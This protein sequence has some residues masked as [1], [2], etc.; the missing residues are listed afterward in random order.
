MMILTLALLGMVLGSFVSI[1][2]KRS[3]EGNALPSLVQ[4][5]VVDS[6]LINESDFF[7]NGQFHVQLIGDSLI[8]V[9]SYKSPSVGFYHISGKQR[10]RIASGDYPIGSFLPSYFD[11]PEYPIVYILDKKSES[12]LVFNVE[13][14]EFLEKIKLDLPEG[15][16]IRILGSKFKKLKTGF[17]IELASSLHDNLHPDYY[18]ESGELIYLFGENGKVKENPFLEYPNEIKVIGGSLKAIN[19]LSFTSDNQSLL[20]SFPHE[21]IIR[22]FDI[23]TFGKA[24]EEIPLPTSRY[25]DYQLTGSEGIVTFEDGLGGMAGAKKIN[26][27]TNHYFTNISETATRII[28]QTWLIGD[29]SEGLNRTSH[30]M[31]YDK[32]EEKW[33]E[34]SNPLNILDIGMLAG[35]ANDTLYFYEGSLMKQD[36]KY[37]KRAV[38]K[39]IEE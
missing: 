23:N 29:E 13:K 20:F 9:S 26:I 15:K 8:G 16:E 24:L 38:L 2:C 11:A 14:Q 36:E 32:E 39:P 30:L 21:K 28:I 3:T 17:L 6:T 7:M 27:P 1:S 33:S 31:V 10:K 37:I 25:F 34:T 5:T 35:V 19:Y 4:L 12:I 22:R 18:R